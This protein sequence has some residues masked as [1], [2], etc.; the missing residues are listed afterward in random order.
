MHRPDPGQAAH[1]LRLPAA[2]S[3]AVRRVE[4]K[5]PLC[6]VPL[7]FG[8]APL[9]SRRPVGA[10]FATHFCRRAAS[11]AEMHLPMLIA[12]APLSSNISSLGICGSAGRRDA[13]SLALQ[14]AWRLP[15]LPPGHGEPACSASAQ[16]H[17]GS[18]LAQERCS[19]LF[20]SVV[21]QILRDVFQRGGVADREFATIDS[22]QAAVLEAPQDATDGFGGQPEVVCDV[23]A[24]HRQME[25]LR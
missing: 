15:P 12:A 17:A 13:L 7:D 18:R 25:C 20:L 23:A 2:N 6:A 5:Q 10:I 3:R 11:T 24:R 1:E 14:K 21:Q 19:V 16:P 22:E 9:R 4:S 8:V